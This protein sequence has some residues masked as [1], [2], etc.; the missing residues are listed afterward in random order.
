MSE[1]DI[2]F[3][4]SCIDDVIEKK[5]VDNSVLQQI[6]WGQQIVKQKINNNFG[7]KIIIFN[8]F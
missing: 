5:I 8:I 6:D 2:K 3:I 4:E 1:T 7:K